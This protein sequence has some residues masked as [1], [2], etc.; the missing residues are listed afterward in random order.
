MRNAKNDPTEAAEASLGME[1][2]VPAQRR[3][4]VWMGKEL[5]RQ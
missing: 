2:G 5:G 4:C 3:A 1:A